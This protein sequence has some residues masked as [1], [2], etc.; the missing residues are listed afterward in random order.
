MSPRAPPA[1]PLKPLCAHSLVSRE[2][3]V[4]AERA[5]PGLLTIA[6]SVRLVQNSPSQWANLL[7]IFL[8]FFFLGWNAK[9]R[10]NGAICFYCGAFPFR[11]E[12]VAGSFSPLTLRSLHQFY[13][14]FRHIF[15]VINEAWILWRPT[16]NFLPKQPPQ[17]N[18]MS[19]FTT[20][21]AT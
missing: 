18:Q 15:L 5:A 10:F 11:S 12:A 7:T 21:N 4:C 6:L 8:F 19:G 9:F 20:G 3:G 13:L 1:S 14:S 16:E 17:K 2:P